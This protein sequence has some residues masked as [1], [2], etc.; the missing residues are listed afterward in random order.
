[1]G[2]KAGL[3]SA[4]VVVVVVVP[5][6]PDSVTVVVTVGIFRTVW[7]GHLPEKGEESQ[8]Q[9]HEM[10]GSARKV[11]M[12]RASSAGATRDGI[13]SCARAR[14]EG[15]GQQH[16]PSSHLPE[17]VPLPPDPRA[18]G[19]RTGVMSWSGMTLAGGSCCS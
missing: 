18:S 16:C 17:P 12:G 11:R 15:A 10:P 3:T 14:G 19:G 4:T 9:M 7:A 1:M 8:A 13:V 6:G 2:S 5:D